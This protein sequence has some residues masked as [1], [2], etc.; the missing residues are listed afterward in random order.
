LGNLA[1]Y[2]KYRPKSLDEVVGQEHI[3]STLKNALKTK[4]LSHAYLFTGPHGVGKTSV[5]RILAFEINGLKYTS[6][7]NLDIIEIDA[8][9]NRRIDEIRQL[10]EKIN[11][12]PI[13]ADYKIYIV[14]EVHMLTKEAFNA[15]LKTLEEPPSHAIFILATTEAHKLPATIISRTQRFQFK[16]VDEKDVLKHLSE[17]AKKESIDIDE[18]ALKIIVSHAGGSV[19]DCISLLEQ[20]GSGGGKINASVVEDSIGM[21]SNDLIN[22]LV[23]DVSQGKVSEVQGTLNELYSQGIQPLTLNFQII[24]HLQSSEIDAFKLDMIEKLLKVSDSSQPAIAINTALLKIT[25]ENSSAPK[26]APIKSPELQPETLKTADKISAKEEKLTEKEVKVS[27]PKNETRITTIGSQL[28]AKIWKSVLSTI[29]DTNNSLYAVLRMAHPS[30]DDNKIQLLFGFEFH[31]K[32][33]QEDRNKKLVEDTIEKLT[34]KSY[35]VVAIHDPQAGNQPKEEVFVRSGA[36]S[37]AN[38]VIDLMGGGEVVE[39]E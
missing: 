12:A 36:D 5:A 19:R 31:Q 10:R 33:A 37:V 11:V 24:K 28:D 9:S 35:A 6:E 14:D 27:A 4:A 23:Y 25:L 17:I 21:A 16:K 26:A 32:R 38:D 20:V 29:K 22:N 3:V 34:G 7:Q 30:V 15:L 8:A 1:L 18:D 13:S 2:R 39:I